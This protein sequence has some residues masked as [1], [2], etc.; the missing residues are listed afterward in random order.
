VLAQRFAGVDLVARDPYVHLLQ[1]PHFI[2][3][4]A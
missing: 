3:R 4:G 1:A 2:W